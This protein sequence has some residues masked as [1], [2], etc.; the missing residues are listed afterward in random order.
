[1]SR[2]WTVLGISLLGLGGVAVG[3][4]WAFE[5]RQAA[6][7]SL[8]ALVWGASTALGALFWVMLGVTARTSWFVLVRRMGEGLVASLPLLALA[9]IPILLSLEELYPWVPGS[10]EMPPHVEHAVHAKRAFLNVPFYYGRE[11]F[12]WA[13][14]VGLATV[15]L[16]W[17]RA[18]DRRNPER[19]IARMRALSAPGFFVLTLVGSFAATD[20]VMTLDPAWYSTIFGSYVLIGGFV[21][22]GGWLALTAELAHRSGKLAPYGAEHR[23]ALGT[24][25]FATMCAWAWFAF[26]QFFIIWIADVPEEIRWYLDRFHGAWKWVAV[27]VV[28]AHWALPFFLLLMKPIKRHPVALAAIGVWLSA[29]H[30]VNMYWIVLPKLHTHQPSV[31]WLDAMAWIAVTGALVTGHAIWT[32]RVPTVPEADPRYPAAL[33]YEGT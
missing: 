9:F 14:F 30:F 19:W 6:H 28:V 5:P 7:A 21:S 2:R 22:A 17:S 1:M 31:H 13:F 25:V 23:Q 10:G 8:A 26:A 4:G 11:A 32:S 29:A 16:A 24:V 3:V 20:W 12:Y 15:L 27:G 18:L 33:E